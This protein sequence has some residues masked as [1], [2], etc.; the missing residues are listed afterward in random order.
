MT[1]GKRKQRINQKALRDWIL[2][3]CGIVWV[4]YFAFMNPSAMNPYFMTIGAGALFGPGV[5]GLW[6]AEAEG[7]DKDA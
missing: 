7:D 2:L 3:V 1:E 4:S 6:R 5:V